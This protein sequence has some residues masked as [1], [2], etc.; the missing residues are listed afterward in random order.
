MG[1][2]SQ[3]VHREG[4]YLQ[5]AVS[6][7]RMQQSMQGSLNV[8]QGGDLRMPHTLAERANRKWV[9]RIQWQLDTCSRMWH[10]SQNNGHRLLQLCTAVR[11]ARSD[12]IC[13]IVEVSG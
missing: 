1:V 12:D 9:L 2:D 8:M 4:Q 13:N 6:D 3:N 5:A 10:V 7:G 11:S